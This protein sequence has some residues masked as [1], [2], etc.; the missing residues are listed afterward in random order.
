MLAVL[1]WLPMLLSQPGVVTSDTKIYLY[2]DPARFLSQVASMWDPDVALGTVTHQTIGYLL[3][4]GPF[5]WLLSALHVPVWVSQ[6]LWAG[7]ILF[8]AAAGVLFLCRTIELRG[9]GRFVAALAF[10]LSPYLLQYI[11]RISVILL[12]WAGLPWLVALA[13]RSVRQGGWRHPA[14]FAIVVVLIGGI[15]ASSLLYVG[16]APA[17][18]LPYAVFVSKEASGRDAWAAAGRIALLSVGVSLW[19][20][21]GLAIEGTYGVDV[22][23][24][25]ETVQATSSASLA[26]DVLRGLGYWYFYGGDQLGPWVQSSVLYT[27]QLWLIAASFAVP[28]LAFLSAAVVRWRH[29]AYFVIVIVFGT[30]LSVGP[31]PLSSPSLVGSLLKYLMTNSTA[32]LAMRSTDRATPLVVLGVA[33]LLGSGVTAVWRRVRPLGSL[34]ALLAV[35]LVLFNN[36]AVWNGDTVADHFVMQDPPPAAVTQAAAALNAT[37]PGTRVFAIPGNDFSAERWGDTVDTVW[38]ALLDRPF[39]TR[40]QQ[41]MGSVATA[42]L[43]YAIDEPMQENTADWNA[44][45]PVARLMS[46]GDVLV[47]YDTAYERYDT[48]RPQELAAQLATTPAGLSDP[49]AYGSPQPNVGTMPMTDEEALALPTGT[50]W[51][52]PL[53]SYTVDDPRP[54]ARAESDSDA[55]V[56]DGDANGIVDAAD[57][58]LLA[59]DDAIYYAGT[60]DADP[61]ELAALIGQGA[62]LV[63]TDTNAKQSF[64]W[65]TLQENAGAI[66]TASQPPDTTDPSDFPVDLFPGAPADAQTTTDQEGVS[67]VTASSYG[68]PVAYLPEDRASQAMDGNLDTAWEV[69]PSGSPDGQWWQATF[70]GPVD[71]DQVNLVQ[72]RTGDTSHYI[73]RVTLTFDGRHPFT[74]DLGSASRTPAGQT[75]TFPKRSFTALRIRIDG[76]NG[77]A[78]AG[79]GPPVGLAEVRVA[80]QE[81][82]E[83]VQMPGDLLSSAGAGSLSD[84]LLLVMDRQRT[85]QIS[86]RSDPEAALS[87]SFTLP[88]ARTFTLSGTADIS[89]LIPDNLID[90]LV[91]TTACDGSQ[92]TFDSSGRLPGDLDAGAA[93]AFD[94]NPQTAWQPGFDATT[95]SYL[96]AQLPSPVTFDQMN[97]QVVADGQHSV[98]TAVTVSTENGSRHVALPVVPDGRSPGATVT[99]PI[100]FPALTGQDITVTFTSVRP[101]TTVN[102]YSQTPITLPLGIAEVGIPGISIAP[103]PTDIPSTCRDDLLTID[104][105]P[106]DISVTG[107]SQAALD[108]S[109]LTV[110][111]CG[112]DAGGITLAAGTHV[113]QATDGHS[114]GF[115]LN[116]LVL[117]SAAGGAA[118]PPATGT[119]VS[120]PPTAPAPTVTV[121]SQNATSWKLHV[122]GV[123][124]PFLLALG[125]SVDPGWEAT[126]KGGSDLGPSELVDG[127]ANG[128]QVTPS[129]VA[130][131]KRHGGTLDVTITWEPQHRVW[132]ALAVSSLVLAGCIVLAWRPR[133]RRERGPVRRPERE[134]ATTT[135]AVHGRLD[136]QVLGALRRRHPSALAAGGPTARREEPVTAP[137]PRPGAGG[138]RRR[139]SRADPVLASPLTFGGNRPPWHRIAIAGAIAFLVAAAVTAP[140]TGVAVCL[141]VVT[142]LA[143]PR[144][145]FI[146]V[147]GSVGLVG[148]AGAVTVTLQAIH[149][150]PEGGAWTGAMGMANT[151]AWMGVVFL[152]ADA[153]VDAVR[154]IRPQPGVQKPPA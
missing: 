145:R 42:D 19:W 32:G 135:P 144:A 140:L 125:E 108:G 77:P 143:V 60:L 104:G 154:R 73:T 81:L 68:N 87:R 57:V 5:Y 13:A 4:M 76:V 96:Q 21:V 53:E 78:S 65:A 86:P 113:L 14:L 47:E 94:G 74:T 54:I 137:A 147:L 56:V 55:L 117:D 82:H 39:V 12:P 49:V 75:I 132:L 24:Y 126:V 106:V 102:Y 7:T 101:E 48:P 70:T 25:T 8:A 17:L 38:P 15:N 127:F 41:I 9:P 119:Q 121:T 61:A 100:S 85:D 23:K 90:C 45:A 149:H 34:T 66:E 130:L 35:A 10:M 51:P 141:A 16:V 136:L 1:A 6:R 153:L 33:V 3:P 84:R 120:A 37:H 11:G 64:R 114:T 99:V 20:I 148:G 43:L 111:L 46:A 2:L 146:L 22:L 31:H 122:S 151:L 152:G 62:T 103:P 63:V 44:L 30:I 26:S 105:R 123:T 67:S 18:W 88:T 52:P 133:R 116:Q 131:A 112:P 110:S 50:A 128:W 36:P 89:T 139:P 109:G 91:G 97:L 98:P 29:R 69:D 71:T 150:Y 115:D 28:T 93:S 92:G 124:Q 134:P 59:G 80:G 72:P 83:V 142:A 118:S 58:G 129:Q 27:Q 95:G 40:E 107:T 138:N 79:I